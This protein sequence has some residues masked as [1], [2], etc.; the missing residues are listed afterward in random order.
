MQRR[1]H[2]AHE[3]TLVRAIAVAA[4]MLSSTDREV[5]ICGT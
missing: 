5:K 4:Q 1:E 2:L 3:L